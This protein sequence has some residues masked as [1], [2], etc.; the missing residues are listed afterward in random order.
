[1]FEDVHRGKVEGEGGE[2]RR[3][4]DRLIEDCGWAEGVPVE[5]LCRGKYV[6]FQNVSTIQVLDKV[7][8]IQLH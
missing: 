7:L 3:R 2:R 6:Y 8:F 1:M 4:K 5:R